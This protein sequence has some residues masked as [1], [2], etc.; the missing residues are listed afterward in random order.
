MSQLDIKPDNN[1]KLK[2]ILPYIICAIA[3][4]FYVYEFLIRIMPSVMTSELMSTY[5]IDTGGLGFMLALFFWGYTPLQIPVGLLYDKF[6]PRRLLT[7]SISI[8]A[9]ATFVFAW[10][11][12]IFIASIARLAMGATGAFAY[13]GALVT[14]SRWFP[15]RY[16]A[17]YTG[18]VQMMGCI[19]SIIGQSPVSAIKSHIGWRQTIMWIAMF[20]AI[21]AA[22]NWI[23]IRDHP[24]NKRARKTSKT[25]SSLK[26]GIVLKNPQTWWIGIAGFACWSP[27]TVFAT[28]WGLP[29]LGNLYHISTTEA[30]YL[31]DMIWIGI[32]IG[33]PI[34]GWWSNQSASRNTPLK[35]CF[36]V[37][38]LCAIGI[39]Y[40]GPLPKVLMGVLLLGFGFA[41]SAQAVTFGLV[42]DNNDK[43][44]I[45]TAIGFNN[46]AV[47][48]GGIIFQPLV[49]YLLQV[50]DPKIVQSS[51]GI[52]HTMQAYHWSLA[53]IPL[54]YVIGLLATQFLIKETHCQRALK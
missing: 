29:F 45:G 19:G 3:A 39:I 44:M 22:L 54:C 8:C 49:G 38:L 18:L 4:S 15:A 6:G 46:M 16:F 32:A 42:M 47:I 34:V 43:S 52:I 11:D 35:T 40:M 1:N 17:F 12:D 21:F 41:A 10:T 28:L 33:S 26:L 5:N 48:A 25:S 13:I 53:V 27:I 30:T 51:S 37:G 24:D 20:G 36:L 23:I 9:L 2:G 14:A 31:N 7:L 50:L